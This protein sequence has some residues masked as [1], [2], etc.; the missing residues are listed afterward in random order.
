MYESVTAEVT[1]WARER[2]SMI[3]EGPTRRARTLNLYPIL[4]KG[5]IV[6][7]ENF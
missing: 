4:K 1:A 6:G 7:G 2:A 5:R 3:S